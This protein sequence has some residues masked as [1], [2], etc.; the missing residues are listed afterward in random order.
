MSI[1]LSDFTGVPS[2]RRLPRGLMTVA[3]G[4]HQVIGLSMALIENFKDRFLKFQRYHN[5]ANLFSKLP[6]ST[7]YKEINKFQQK[8]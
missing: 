5:L 4:E 6:E 3:S 8:V 7:F 2:L 1:M